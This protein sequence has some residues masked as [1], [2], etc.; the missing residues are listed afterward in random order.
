MNL[1]LPYKRRRDGHSYGAGEVTLPFSITKVAMAFT[2][3]V[4]LL[5]PSWILP[6]SIPFMALGAS[7]MICLFRK[8]HVYA[9]ASRETIRR[10]H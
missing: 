6:G 7:F 5:M 9:K 3:D 2:G 4:P 10:P 8:F 1:T